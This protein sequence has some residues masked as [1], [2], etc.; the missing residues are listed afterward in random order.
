MTEGAY[1]NYDSYWIL[2]AK[3]FKA[4]LLDGEVI[5]E[6]LLGL[7]PI[8]PK[9]ATNAVTEANN[10]VAY[11]HIPDTILHFLAVLVNRQGYIVKIVAST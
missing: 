8:C 1:P 4:I 7:E 2:S 3:H 11:K 5:T 10:K 9:D 6:Y